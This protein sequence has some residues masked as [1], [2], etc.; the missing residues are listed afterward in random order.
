MRE[1]LLQEI[2]DEKQKPEYEKWM[3]Q[4]A[5]LIYDIRDDVRV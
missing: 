3:N 2:I 1:F 5:K 4:A